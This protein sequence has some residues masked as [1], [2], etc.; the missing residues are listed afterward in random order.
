MIH[1]DLLTFC[2][3]VSQSVRTVSV[4]IRTLYVLS[5][6]VRISFSYCSLQ[7][8]HTVLYFTVL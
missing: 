3:E 4:P 5:L 1:H 8:V 6:T 2:R 7:Y